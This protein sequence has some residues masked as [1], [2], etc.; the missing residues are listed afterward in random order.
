[1]VF[2]GE[3]LAHTVLSLNR[4]FWGALIGGAPALVLGILMGL[5]RPVRAIFDPLFAAI[6]PIPKSSIL[7]IALLIFGLGEASKIFLV[8]LG[9]FFPVVMNAATGVLAIDATYLDVGRN[10]KASRG[11]PFVGD[12]VWHAWET[13]SVQQMYVGLFTIA[14]IGLSLTAV[15]NELEKLPL[16]WKTS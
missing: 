12:L 16:P 6:Y 13:F 4:L 9:V 5:N 2:S 10:F 7:P 15:V 3:L 14:I 11:K 1:M 8:A